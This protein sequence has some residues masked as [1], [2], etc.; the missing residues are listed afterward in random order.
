MLFDPFPKTKVEDLFDRENELVK[1]KNTDTPISL[2][3]GVRRVGKTSLV[4]V[5]LNL[6]DVRGIFIDCRRFS[7]TGVSIKDFVSTLEKVFY[8]FSKRYSTLIK[9]F[10][11]LKSISVAGNSIEIKKHSEEGIIEILDAID[12]WAFKRKKHIFL[13][14]DEAQN[15]R[16]FRK[17]H[18]I[19]FPEI[20]GYAY[21]N[22]KALKIILTGSEAGILREFV[23]IENAKSPLYGRYMREII[24]EPFEYEKSLNF[25][26][27]GFE[28]VGFKY[29][30]KEIRKA[31][32][33]LDG[34]VG[35]L[36]YFGKSLIDLKG[37]WNEA[38]KKTLEIASNIVHNEIKNLSN[39]SQ[40]YIYILKAISRGINNWSA[41]KKAVE[42]SEKKKL[43]N[44]SFSRTLNHLIKMG[45]ISK[46]NNSYVI[47]DPII[48]KVIGSFN[49]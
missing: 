49:F 8:S 21:D 39:L 44:S 36:V 45:Y 22:F 1:L 17:A 19:S 4:K 20:F 46:T 3:L 25:L 48:K 2:L 37:N 29:S 15:L 27:K 42:Y 5:F 26:K 18:G 9:I 47:T 35:W 24:L 7:S 16:F 40:R 12:N 11:N 41:I 28:E 31:V 14:F 6:P 33:I 43:T 23:G 32:D 30:E 10:N 34:I 38:M 13:I